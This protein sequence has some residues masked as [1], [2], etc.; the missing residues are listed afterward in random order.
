MNL[1]CPNYATHFPKEKWFVCCWK[2]ETNKGRW[3]WIKLIWHFFV[4]TFFAFKRKIHSWT[5][6][7]RIS[8]NNL[9]GNQHTHWHLCNRYDRCANIS[10]YIYLWWPVFMYTVA[11]I[12]THF[13]CLP[14]YQTHSIRNDSRIAHAQTHFEKL[15]CS[16]EKK[17]VSF[18]RKIEDQNKYNRSINIHI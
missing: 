15:L 11:C 2:G 7:D 5:I 16:F 8:E 14:A 18:A 9:Q 4:V 17:R 3:W 6:D 13:Y 12:W 10:V 1:P